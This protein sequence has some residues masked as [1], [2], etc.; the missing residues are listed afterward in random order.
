M[1]HQPQPD[2]PFNRPPRIRPLLV[3][4]TIDLPAP[5]QPPEPDS[6]PLWL[7]LALPLLTVVALA[8]A[9]AAVG[10][11]GNVWLFAVPMAVTTV[12]GA[13]A[14]LLGQRAQT[15]RRQTDF[16]ARSAF[17]AEQLAVATA[18][19]RKRYEQESHDRHYL[20]PEPEE[21]L[22]L[23]GARGVD[24]APA[25]RLWE[26]R[27]ADDDFLALRVG[28][29]RVACSTT[30]N[31]P[32]AS[33]D[34][35]NDRRLHELA[36]QYQWLTGVPISLP[37]AAVGAVGIAGPRSLTLQL[38]DALIWQAAVLHAPDDLRIAV[39]LPDAAS[40]AAND[41]LRWL[42]H[43]VPLNNDLSRALRM[44]AGGGTE[45]DRLLS[46]L[47]DQL[48]RRRDAADRPDQAAARVLPHILIIVDGDGRGR[49]Q[50]LFAE[51]MRHGPQLGM[52]L[53]F[54]VERWEDIPSQCALLLD[55]QHAAARMARAGGPWAPDLLQIDQADTGQSERLARRLAGIRLAAAGSSQD[56]PRS[57]RL[58]DLLGIST[59]TDLAPPRHWDTPPADVWH[60]AVPIGVQAGG[61]PFYL[62][63]NEQRHGPH[64]IIAG[65]TGAGKSVLLQAIIA[66]LVVTH[67][68]QQ[69]QLLLIDFKGGASLA[70]FDGLPHSVGF[71]S[72]LE[73]RL[74][75]RAMTAIKSEI[76]RRKLLLKTSAVRSGAKIE[77]IRD[78]RSQ[79]L[80]TDLQPLP[81]LLIVVDEFDELARNNPAFVGELVRVVKQGRS[82]G[83]HLLLATQQP[84]R[85]VSDEIR[86][87]L[88]YF[89]ALRLGSSE[90]SREML[91][92]PDAAFL[93]PDIPGRAYVR[94]G[95]A[96]ELFQVAQVGGGTWSAG[97]SV[98]SRG[99]QV[100]FMQ[101]GN[102]PTPAAGAEQ[103]AEP[104]VNDL[105]MLIATLTTAGQAALAATARHSG[106]HPQPIWQPP[107]AAH[108]ALAQ[109]VP[110][111]PA[112]PLAGWNST[113]PARLAV[114]VGQLDVPQESC[115][116][117]LEVDLSA[118]HLAVVGA[119]GS[120]K[121]TLLRTLLLSLALRYAPTDLWCYA[122]DAGGQGLHALTAL[123]HLGSL[124]AVRDT[125][126]IRKLIQLL[127]AT[128]SERQALFRE[129]GAGDLATYVTCS[130]R[131]LPAIVICIDK[132]ALLRE[133]FADRRADDPIVDDLVRLARSG[134]PYG[135]HFVI[136]ADR[137]ADIT[138]R[139]F[140]L[141]ENRIALRLPELY[142]YH[143]AIGGRVSGTIPATLPGRGIW[144]HADYGPLDLQVALPLIDAAAEAGA[145]PGAGSLSE[146]DVLAELRAT[147]AAIRLAWQ[148]E[149][150]PATAA[151]PV[152]LLP[153]HIALADLQSPA[154]PD[155]SAALT[156]VIGCESMRLQPV[157]L[158]LDAELPHAL[159]VGGRRSGK[160]TA[161]L[162]IVAALLNRYGPA[163]IEL[164]V[165]DSPRGGLRAFETAATRVV[166][167]Q[168][169][170][171]LAALVE[172]L[173]LPS[174]TRQRLLVID[175]YTL[176]RDVAREQFSPS[177]S[178]ERNFYTLLNDIAA[179]NNNAG[180][181]LLVAANCAY[182]DDG[183]LR[184]LDQLR[185][186]ILLWPGRY[187]GGTRL[188]GVALPLETQRTSEQPPGRALLVREDELQVIQVARS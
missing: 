70:V 72:D 103:R 74:A 115:R 84:A 140:A 106:W 169:A 162:T 76:R 123:P 180:M 6:T 156:G 90:D 4:T 112:A 155:V 22:A 18:T 43:T 161:L 100:V 8:G 135:I 93:P 184:A 95:A 131:R 133:E 52:S 20:A 127:D 49:S 65:A 104:P 122:I 118:A 150:A 34:G 78:Y 1:S 25:P 14:T 107:L 143:E 158:C 26:R 144:M 68:P 171:Q 46:S 69:L 24:C 178:G 109:V 128:I 94:V 61:Q 39:V 57:V 77:N 121:T 2:Q 45:R 99:P 28:L 53:V 60:S 62:D 75:E 16:A 132:I 92:Q 149:Y 163:A 137:V 54:L 71:V 168:T 91:L 174:T 164:Y 153:A 142:D 145:E 96:C 13:I 166:Y 31:L 136:S 42:P 32:P 47:L 117:A 188:L 3:A 175:D 12:M 89:I 41:W 179:G 147:A 187:D 79:M 80:H 141:Y 73:G 85:A 176:Q 182:P 139:L 157:S 138:S 48:S 19:L 98:N 67:A 183:P 154:T 114:V 120:G 88:K 165:V 11:G 126:R 134:R 51:V 172:Q 30:V 181:H 170:A 186:G 36:V 63:L 58:F 37:L 35:H 23:A 27:P 129:A 17:F 7:T 146:S 33:R 125:E 29:G 185:N 97:E 116:A 113:P 5:P 55:L 110:L 81:A 66:A 15:R 102:A 21:L 56:L 101:R 50:P 38:R 124:I 108:L 86:T 177:Y 10:R 151:P 9:L 87:Q 40:A 152:Q 160:T 111:D 64:G 59:R 173:A 167:A 130:G 83:V 44:C 148:Q 82:L 105:A 159:I 119:P